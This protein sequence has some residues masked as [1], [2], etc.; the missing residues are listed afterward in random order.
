M[1]DHARITSLADRLIALEDELR[2]AIDRRRRDELHAEVERLHDELDGL[3][4]CS[5]TPSQPPV[6]RSA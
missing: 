1:D 6:R 4:R 2:R 5:L 3:V